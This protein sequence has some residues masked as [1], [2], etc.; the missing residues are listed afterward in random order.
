MS[1]GPPSSNRHLKSDTIALTLAALAWGF[2][3]SGGLLRELETAQM[4]AAVNFSLDK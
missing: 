1:C 4:T 2:V 3:N